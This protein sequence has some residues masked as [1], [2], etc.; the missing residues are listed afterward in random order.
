LAGL[1][2][3]NSAE[4]SEGKLQGLCRK[5]DTFFLAKLVPVPRAWTSGLKIA[6]I[7]TKSYRKNQ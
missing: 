3:R 7:A 4:S 5:I 2:H 6:E 1:A